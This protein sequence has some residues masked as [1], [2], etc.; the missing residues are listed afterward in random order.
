[1]LLTYV[2]VINL[3]ISYIALNNLSIKNINSVTYILKSLCS[4][5]LRNYAIYKIT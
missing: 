1:M 4:T 3:L 5:L 2:Y